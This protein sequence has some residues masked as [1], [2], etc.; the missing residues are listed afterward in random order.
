MGV[1]VGGAPHL[2]L[3]RDSSHAWH[4]CTDVAG[5]TQI[6]RILSRVSA[7]T[8]KIFLKWDSVTQRAFSEMTLEIFLSRLPTTWAHQLEC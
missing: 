3:H 1:G 8:S 7:K 2:K 5:W 4:R 6:S